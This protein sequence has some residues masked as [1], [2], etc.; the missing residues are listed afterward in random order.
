[1]RIITVSWRRRWYRRAHVGGLSMIAGGLAAGCFGVAD[2]FAARWG[3]ADG[4]RRTLFGAQAT[5]VPILALA[6]AVLETPASGVSGAW[7]DTLASGLGLGL[8]HLIGSVC[9]YRALEVGVVSVV[10]PLAGTFGVVTAALAVAFGHPMSAA[11]ALALGLASLGGVVAARAPADRTGRGAVQMKGGRRWI[12]GVGWAAGASLALGSSF[13]GLEWLD[14]RGI[15]VL[16]SVAMYRGICALGLGAVAFAYPVASRVGAAEGRRGARLVRWTTLGLLD[17][18]GMVAFGVGCDLGEVAVVAVVASLFPAVTVGLAQWRL[19]ERLSA[20][21][22][23]GLL[24][25]L[26]GLVAVASTGR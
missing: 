3:R 26:A 17:A 12:S 7:Q 25:L 11:L 8:I 10:S 4:W 16:W 15:G 1:M 13:Y 23:T 18:G 20:P 19:K 22:W 14:E 24:A 5:S 6:A 2:F 21:Q 9:L